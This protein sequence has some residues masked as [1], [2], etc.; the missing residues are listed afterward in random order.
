MIMRLVEGV[1]GAVRLAAEQPTDILATN[2]QRCH[3]R[4][5]LVR[6]DTVLP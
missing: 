5:Q 6:Y 2:Q 3:D 1:C 4:L